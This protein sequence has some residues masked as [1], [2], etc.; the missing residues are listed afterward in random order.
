MSNK[1]KLVPVEPTE[2]MLIAGQEAFFMHPRGAL[3]DCEESAR[4]YRDMLAAAPE[5]QIDTEA[6]RRLL[7]YLET[8][9]E[10]YADR[11][12]NAPVSRAIYP[13]RLAEFDRQIAALKVALS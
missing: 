5:K 2:D 7:I 4:A 13:I 11:A 8:R 1:W 3:E 6:L 10:I 9:R 12:K